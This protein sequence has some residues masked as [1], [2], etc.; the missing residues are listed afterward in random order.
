M[1]VLIAALLVAS[2]VV[3]APA[4]TPS[5]RLPIPDRLVVLT[6][7]DSSRSDF[8]IVRPILKQYGFG[9]T[10]FITEGFDFES[11]KRD[12]MKYL[13]LNDYNVI[14]MRELAKYSDAGVSPEDPMAIINLRREGIKR[15]DE[16]G[17]E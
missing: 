8:T 4:E 13:A 17:G 3:A 7:D 9:A 6:F 1:R 5:G 15:P 14:A 10:F 16:S 11:N 12:Y 2:L